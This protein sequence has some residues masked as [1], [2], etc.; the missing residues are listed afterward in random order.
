MKHLNGSLLVSV[1]TETTGLNPFIHDV[2]QVAVVPLYPDFTVNKDLRPWYYNI[3]PARPKNLDHGIFRK[4]PVD[5]VTHALLHGMDYWRAADHFVE[6]VDSLPLPYTPSGIRKKLI[7]VA[8]NWYHD[9]PFM[10]SWLT[11][12]TFDDIFHPWCRDL[13]PVTQFI[14]DWYERHNIQKEHSTAIDIPFPKASL[15]Y[16]C[17]VLGVTNEQAHDAFHDAIAT[18]ECWRRLR[19]QYPE[20]ALCAGIGSRREGTGGVAGP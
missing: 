2:W 5:R 20:A 12:E 11:P 9:R 7:P 19:I 15:G 10:Q 4:I 13:L 3:R 6:W 17:S 8:Q 1:D 16:I 14:N 18:A